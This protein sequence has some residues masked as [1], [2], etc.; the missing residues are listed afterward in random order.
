[1]K[2]V[3]EQLRRGQLTRDEAAEQILATVDELER[4]RAAA[5]VRKAKPV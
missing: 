5:I 4:A 2:L 3:A 1:M